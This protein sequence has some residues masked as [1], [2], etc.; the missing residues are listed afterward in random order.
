MEEFSLCENLKFFQEFLF[1]ISFESN[2][3][4]CEALAELRPL[5]KCINTLI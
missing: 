5:G 1:K 4:S 3:V 2:K